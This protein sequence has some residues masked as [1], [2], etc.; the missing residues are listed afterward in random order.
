MED[1]TGFQKLMT[2]WIFQQSVGIVI[3][4]TML[5]IF[6]YDHYQ[7]DKREQLKQ[8]KIESMLIYERDVL[9]EAVDKNTRA[10]ED[11][12]ILMTG[13]KITQKRQNNDRR[14]LFNH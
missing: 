12:S 6:V 4:L 3:A 10:F 9:K 14:T 2:D 7:L 8:A 11:F 1:K 5:G 13:Q